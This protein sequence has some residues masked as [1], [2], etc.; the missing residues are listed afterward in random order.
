MES[1][2]VDENLQ[3][4]YLDDSSF[5]VRSQC[6]RPQQDK[7]LAKAREAFSNINFKNYRGS[8]IFNIQSSSP[9]F[10]NVESVKSVESKANTSSKSN[11]DHVALEGS[12]AKKKKIDV[13]Y[14]SD[15]DG[16]LSDDVFVKKKKSSVRRFKPVTLEKDVSSN[17]SDF[18][19]VLVG[20]CKAILVQ[21]FDTDYLWLCPTYLFTILLF[22]FQ[23]IVPENYEYKILSAEISS[24]NEHNQSIVATIRV[25][26]STETG[27]LKW[28]TEFE[29]TSNSDFRVKKTWGDLADSK[30]VVFKVN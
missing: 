23:K 30:R 3:T 4:E 6:A 22:V 11:S 18:Q 29:Q 25:N 28:L 20:V 2:V 26:I 7:D 8:Q 27:A 12:S 19:E 24:N 16:S 15:S 14:D 10:E 5:V 1:V 21:Y 17:V 9:D 13:L